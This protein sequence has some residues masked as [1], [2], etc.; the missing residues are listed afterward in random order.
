MREAR[1]VAAIVSL[2]IAVIRLRTAF[3]AAVRWSRLSS[4]INLPF[5]CGFG[6]L[7]GS[8]AFRKMR[9]RFQKALPG[10][11][12]THRR[13]LIPSAGKKLFEGASAFRTLSLIGWGLLLQL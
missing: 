8:N 12:R 2:V 9:H 11:S 10:H 4:V 1:I 5:L 13:D 6:T 7:T 3:A